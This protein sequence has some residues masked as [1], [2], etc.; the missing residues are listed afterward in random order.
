MKRLLFII[1]SLATG[2]TNSSLDALYEYLRVRFDISVFAISHCP[3]NHKY[4]FDEI[5]L[6]VDRVLSY[7][8][9]NYSDLKGLDKVKATW[10]KL[11]RLLFRRLQRDWDG[12]LEKRA[13]RDVR[14]K[15]T[16]DTV[17]GFQE[18]SATKMASLFEE[19]Y[20][21]AWIHSNY[22]AYLDKM[23]SEE[24]IYAQFDR[25]VCV[26]EYTSSVFCRRYPSLDWKVV[27]VYNLINSKKVL[28]LGEEQIDDDRFIRKSHTFVTIGRFS[29]VKRFREIP[30][31][32][33]YLRS[34]GLDFV[35]YIIG[36]S[37]DSVEFRSFIENSERFG[38]KECV[39]WLGGKANPYPYYKASDLYVCLSESEACPMVFKEAQLFGL[40][41]VTTNFPS[42]F[43]FIKGENG[44]IA[45]LAEIGEAIIS[46]VSRINR[47][48]EVQPE[49]LSDSVVFN[50]IDK[51][52][53]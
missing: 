32:A 29:E 20:T 26:S 30:S 49:T 44:I 45:P 24:S 6:P 9:S 16:F 13:V 25:I 33:Q 41:I 10:Y 11:L 15:H 48:M 35:W 42:S 38:V 23:H 2:G 27:T 5:L 46:M 18:G 1:P 14:R 7:S 12:F 4:T 19:A 47:G 50:M 8:F 31:V 28:C 53:V 51:L 21:I 34:R 3:R 40:P 22:D 39:K 52:F 43:E 37:E 36:P 17:I